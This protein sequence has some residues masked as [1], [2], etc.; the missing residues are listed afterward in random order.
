MKNFIIDV[1]S[2]GFLVDVNKEDIFV[3]KKTNLYNYVVVG[4][5]VSID[6]PVLLYVGEATQVDINDDGITRIPVPDFVDVQAKC[7]IQIFLVP[8][9]LGIEKGWAYIKSL[10]T[11]DLSTPWFA[12]AGQ[13]RGLLRL[14]CNE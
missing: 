6:S 12:P 13:P 4:L 5:E 1:K 14:E 10:Y 9:D 3:T 7:N 8:K 11:V 2:V